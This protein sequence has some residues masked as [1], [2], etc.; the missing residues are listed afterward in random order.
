[1]CVRVCVCV[2]VCVCVWYMWLY[3]YICM[4][5]PS[6]MTL[7]SLLV[8]IGSRSFCIFLGRHSTVPRRV[9][10]VRKMIATGLCV[11]YVPTRLAR[12]AQDSSR[13]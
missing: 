12:S 11:D 1:M 3:L 2:C 13:T 10:Y 6:V 7:V 5:F 8:R 9:I 4:W